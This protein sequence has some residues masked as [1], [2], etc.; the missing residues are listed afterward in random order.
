MQ[1]RVARRRPAPGVAGAHRGGAAP[2]LRGLGAAGDCRRRTGLPA[3]RR[4]ARATDRRRAFRRR[5]GPPHRPA[6]RIPRPRPTPQ[7]SPAAQEI[8]L[9]L[10]P[11]CIFLAF[12]TGAFDSTVR[13]ER[14]R[15][16]S[17]VLGAMG[18][19]MRSTLRVSVAMLAAVTTYGCHGASPSRHN[20]IACAVATAFFENPTEQDWRRMSACR[21]PDCVPCDIAWHVDMYNDAR[22]QRDFPNSMVWGELLPERLARH[23]RVMA[24]EMSALRALGLA[25]CKK[26]LFTLVRQSFSEQ[27]VCTSAE[28]TYKFSPDLLTAFT[29]DLLSR[30][31]CERNV[32]LIGLVR[33]RIEAQ[34]E[35]DKRGGWPAAGGSSR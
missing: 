21:N 7:G 6:D 13:P 19:R 30:P 3:P 28:I 15:C 4:P 10:F 29:A 12:G 8:N 32:E 1:A 24:Y 16:D 26:M 14:D 35:W 2:G 25:K 11:E 17:K 23:Y 33:D 9:S 34:R 5:R 22:V 31:G 18:M 27:L 20:S